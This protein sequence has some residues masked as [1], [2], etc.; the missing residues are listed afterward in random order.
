MADKTSIIIKSVDSENKATSRSITDVSKT[1]TNQQLKAFAQALNATSENTYQSSSRVQT[2]D[3]DS[4]QTKSQRN[5][6][7]AKG[8][9]SL[10]VASLNADENEWEL[11]TVKYE[12]DGA[13]CFIFPGAV[14]VEN[15]ICGIFTGNMFTPVAPGEGMSPVTGGVCEVTVRVD[16]NSTYEAGE[17]VVTI[18]GGQG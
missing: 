17:L 5:M 7:L 1:A 11:F 10:A 4:A 8:D 16:E 15:N 12:G 2:T 9:T 18:I 13:A 3:L 14:G 6:Y